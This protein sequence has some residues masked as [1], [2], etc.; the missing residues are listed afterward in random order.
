[1]QAG[2]K[3]RKSSKQSVGNTALKT[4]PTKMIVAVMT[5]NTEKA[6]TNGDG[7]LNNS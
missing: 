6:T 3:P 2:G 4:A 7:K 5:P 1:M